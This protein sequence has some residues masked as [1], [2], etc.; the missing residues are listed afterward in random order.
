MTR[1][2]DFFQGGN[3]PYINSVIIRTYPDINVMQAAWETGDIDFFAALMTDHIDRIMREHANRA[4]F[5]EVPAH[6]YDY[7]GFNL[8][9]PILSDLRVREALVVGLDRRA[10]VDT[11]LLYTS[12]SPRDGATSRMPSSA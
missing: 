9:H 1:N 12:P 8:V 3:R 7:M 6:A 11:C 2:P 10:M 5:R 4:Y